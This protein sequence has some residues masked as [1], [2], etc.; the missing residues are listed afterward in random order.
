MKEYVIANPYCKSITISKQDKDEPTFILCACDGLFD[1]MSDQ[2]AVDF[3]L[4]HLD[5]HDTIA[6]LLV[7]EALRRGS[8]DNITATV[9]WL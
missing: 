8:T 1:V 3:V 7:K 9:A 6:Q 2:D 5:E 4:D